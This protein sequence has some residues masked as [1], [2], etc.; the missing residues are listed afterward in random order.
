MLERCTLVA[1]GAVSAARSNFSG[2]GA[3]GCAFF[4][5]TTDLDGTPLGGTTHNATS[6]GTAL[7]TSGQTGLASGDFVN[8]GGGTEDYR[9]ASGSTKLGN[10]GTTISGV[11]VDLFGLSIPQGAAPDIGAT[12]FEEASG[13]VITG[14]SGAA[15]AA[16]ITHA[17]NENQ[18]NAGTWSATGGTAWSL[19]GTDAPALAI[20]S[21]GVV[22]L[23]SGNFDR[24]T[25][26]S[27]SFNVLRDSATQAVTLNINNVNEAPSFVGPDISVPTLVVNSSMTPISVVSR[28]SDPDSGDSGTYS[29]VGTWPA[30]VTVSSA[31]VISG[32][33][34]TVGTSSNLRVRRTDVGSLTADSNLFGITVSSSSSPVSFSGTVGA[35]SGTVGS[36]FAW[37]GSSLSS[38]FSG[39][40]APF[41]YSVVSGSLPPGLSINSSTGVVSGTP[42]ASGNYSATFRATDTGSNTANSN[43]V[44][45]SIA[46]APSSG[47]SA[48]VGPFSLNTGSPAMAAGEVLSFTAIAGNT[49]SGTTVING[50]VTLGAGGSGLINTFPSSGTWQVNLRNSGGTGRWH[51]VVTAA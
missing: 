38:F 39:S 20:S 12:E 33:P 49:G 30:G 51:N 11:T 2:L 37:S 36:A 47:F 8:T 46:A 6:N 35:Q 31:G 28:F 21:G 24:E 5:F 43:S 50:T 41:A 27:Y 19:T 44:S 14:P 22:T 48:T 4:G 16:S 17:V 15:G 9:R 29:A 40:L 32:A 26:A 18:N 45:F 23:A 1:N 7:G 3:A 25:K 10:T 13:P 42:T 34:T